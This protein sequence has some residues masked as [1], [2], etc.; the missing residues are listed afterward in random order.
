MPEMTDKS[1]YSKAEPKTAEAKTEEL[2]ALCKQMVEEARP[3]T[4]KW[5]DLAE[6]ALRYIYDDQLAGKNRKNGWPSPQLN[7]IFP[8]V[9]QEIATL[10]QRRPNIDAS[11]RGPAGDRKAPFWSKLQQY[12]YDSTLRMPAKTISATL[13]GAAAGWYIG[14]IYEEPK[15][16]W[17]KKARVWKY[18]PCVNLIEPRYFGMDPNAENLEEARYCYCQRLVPVEWALRRWPEFKGE[19]ESEANKGDTTPKLAPFIPAGQRKA[20]TEKGTG[21]D[22]ETPDILSLSN[23]L[24]SARAE[25]TSDTS[26][27]N[28]K[29]MVMITHVYFRDAE[30]TETKTYEEIPKEELLASGAF[31][32]VTVKQNPE[33]ENELGVEKLVILNPE[34]EAFKSLPAELKLQAGDPIER[35]PRNEWPQRLTKKFMQ[36]V[37]PN[38][39]VVYLAGDTIL[40]PDLKKQVWHRDGWPFE[41]GLRLPLPHVPQGLNAVEMA[42]GVQDWVN[43]S[44]AH[45]LNWLMHF[46]DPVWLV[47]DDA[48]AKKSV[49][50]AVAGFVLKLMPGKLNNV[51]REPPPPLND[52]ALTILSTFHRHGQDTMAQH[53][54]G[55]G[56]PSRKGEETATAVAAQEAAASVSVGLPMLFMDDWVVRVMKQVAELD[57]MY[58]EPED[59]ARMVGGDFTPEE[60]AE[61]MDENADFNLDIKLDVGTALPHD[62]ERRKKNLAEIYGLRPN[63]KVYEM[64]LEAADIPNKDEVMK[65][66]AEFAAF[67]QY[68]AQM[69]AAQAAGPGQPGAPVPP[70]QTGA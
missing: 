27:D 22:G 66:D 50:K 20:E 49:I 34:H 5:C 52:G 17:D 69:A 51:R 36:P 6:R 31:G 58:L 21:V 60:V 35:I 46:G 10:A 28:R 43:V 57:R 42:R 67:Q 13:D 1:F 19:I 9:R 45:L 14:Y 3:V 37:Y 12:R 59:A 56:G 33:D 44:A 16:T 48:L 65:S 23:L 61:F 7:F 15:A 4:E 38:G 68:I 55:L 30:E 63:P 62:K 32:M 64:L 18:K 24:L 26:D 2:V 11:S 25:P 39:R 70:A 40:N 47:E 29:R 8:S 53:D 41:I 54:Q